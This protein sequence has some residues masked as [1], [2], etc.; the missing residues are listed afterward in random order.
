MFKEN[1]IEVKVI[2]DSSDPKIDVKFTTSEKVKVI[3]IDQQ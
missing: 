2:N 3:K 1:G